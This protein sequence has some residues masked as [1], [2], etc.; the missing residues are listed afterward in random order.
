MARDAFLALVKQLVESRKR[1]RTT[2]INART[3]PAWSPL[4]R[5]AHV[6]A[7][8]VCT[9]HTCVLYDGSAERQLCRAP[10]Q[11][12][13]G[14]YTSAARRPPFRRSRET[15]IHITSASSTESRALIRVICQVVRNC[16]RF[17]RRA[18]ASS[19]ISEN[20]EKNRRAIEEENRQRG[21]RETRN[22]PMCVTRSCV[23]SAGFRTFRLPHATV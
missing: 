7:P 19:R 2:T 1:P 23:A 20:R 12:I 14:E 8:D 17:T 15:P 3:F 21:S 22:T 18:R 11:P 16:S 5:L 13:S 9:I 4:H 6:L 10:S